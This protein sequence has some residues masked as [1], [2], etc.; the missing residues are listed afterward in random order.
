VLGH[1][2]FASLTSVRV[3]IGPH[4]LLAERAPENLSIQRY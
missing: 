4:D 3:L 1:D 2:A